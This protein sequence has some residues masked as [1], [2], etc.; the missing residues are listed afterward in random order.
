[1]KPALLPILLMLLLAS[2]TITKRRYLPGYTI[3]WRHTAPKLIGG[4]QAQSIHIAKQGAYL[5]Q[6]GS[7]RKDSSHFQQSM[8]SDYYTDAHPDERFGQASFVNIK[9]ARSL[10]TVLPTTRAEKPTHADSLKNTPEICRDANTSLTLGILAWLIPLALILLAAISAA[11]MSAGGDS[12]AFFLVIFA[13]VIGGFIFII[14]GILALIFGG[15]ALAKI[16]EHPDKYSG[17]LRATIGILLVAIPIVGL[18]ILLATA[19]R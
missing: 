14:L 3:N 6:S 13:G 10:V 9:K 18:L 4:M 12:M 11:S 8:Q 17:K 5:S 16:N 1:M 2:C 19:S 7:A 15:T